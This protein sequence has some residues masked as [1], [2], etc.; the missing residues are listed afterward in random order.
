MGM[1]SAALNVAQALEI[2]LEHH[3]ND[4]LNEAEKMYREILQ[5][6]PKHPDALH[7]LG[8]IRYQRNEYETAIDFF[9]QA[10]AVNATIPDF[11]RH[12]GLAWHGLRNFERAIEC[13]RKALKLN[14]KYAETHNNLGHTYRDLGKLD[15]A[16]A[17]YEKAIRL[18]PDSYQ[19]INNL[20]NIHQFQGRLEKAAECYQKALL[21]EPNFAEG[22][23]NLGNILLYQGKPN[24]A[25]EHYQKA[26][27]IH[28]NYPEALL[29]I[30]TRY[31]D[32]GQLAEA[33]HYYKKSLELH[34][35]F[36]GAHSN[37]GEIFKEQGRLPE[38]IE[39]F[40]RAM[41]CDPS[42]HQ[43]HSNLLF[44]LGHHPGV[45]PEALLKEHI[46]WA[47]QHADKFTTSI[48]PHRN[49]AH[50]N[51]C[52]RIGYISADFRKHVV[53]SN[54]EPILA[55]H[56]HQDFKIY[57]YSNV[58]NPDDVTASMQKLA[59][60]WRSIVGM[61][62]DKVAALI[63]EDKIDILIELAGHTAN[64]RLLVFARKPAPVQVSYLGYTATTGLSTIDY[65]LTD[66]F[67]DPSG[68]TECFYTEKMKRVPGSA[69]CYQPL[70]ESPPVSELPALANNHVTFGSFNNLTKITPDVVALWAQV[71][72]I[73]PT[74]K[75]LMK[76]KGL[77]DEMTRRI[78]LAMFEHHGIDPSRLTLIGWEASLRQHVEVYHRVDVALDPFPFNGGIT[79]FE[80]LWMGVPVVTLEGK[81]FVSRMGVRLLEGVKFGDLIAKTSA[82]YVRIASELAKNLSRLQ[83][84]RL[85]LRDR[86]Q[87]S[88]LMDGAQIT[89]NIEMVYRDIW[90]QWCG[91]PSRST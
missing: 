33:I 46:G 15:E 19:A 87:H 3:R 5:V 14:P 68:I 56:N 51:R 59:D 25:L 64:N 69:I 77:N 70:T 41:E 34:P 20:G 82:D 48:P 72:Q 86:M 75:L 73:V 85:E 42:F 57:C 4:R 80:A 17:C 18:K 52:L 53:A 58:L 16:R 88:P 39:S 90:T 44:V 31:K 22:Y 21:I 61:S 67:G 12:C 6:Q 37:L 54:L 91:S 29:N 65:R 83:Q 1:D 40:E 13:Y 7:L 63:R 71:L 76:S 45:P 32:R 27:K 74:A 10:I 50:P 81:T 30:G 23:N 28:P 49:D 78:F 9:K 2:A 47:R 26:L 79:S 35:R 24:E 36:V 8:V 38:A 89:R 43:A 66:E 55:A 84:L 62:D 11:H 60:R